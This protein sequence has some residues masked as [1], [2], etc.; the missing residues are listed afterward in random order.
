RGANIKEVRIRFS[1]GSTYDQV[2]TINFV[3]VTVDRTT[4][5]ITVRATIPNPKGVL[6]D[7]QFAQVQLESGTSDEKVLVPQAALIADQQ[8]IF[9]FGVGERKGPVKGG[10]AGAGSGPCFFGERGLSGGELVLARGVEG[11]RPG[12]PVRATPL[13]PMVGRS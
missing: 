3:D 9:F 10:K 2:G 5:T 12:M 8:G 7:G 1:D 13:P 6:I 4:D 11:F